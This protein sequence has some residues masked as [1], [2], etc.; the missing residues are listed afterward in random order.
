LLNEHILNVLPFSHEQKKGNAMSEKKGGKEARQ[1]MA[2]ERQRR[3]AQL[4]SE[5]QLVVLD[6]RLGKDVG[7]QKERARLVEQVQT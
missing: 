3:R 6:E 2:A 7:A 1:V 4:S 5:Q